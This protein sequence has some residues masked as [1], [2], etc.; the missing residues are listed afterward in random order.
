[1]SLFSTFKTALYKNYGE[2][3]GTMLVHTGA[4]GWILS[5]LAQISAIVFNDK[6]SKEQKSFLIP[7]EVADAM[8]NILSFYVVT[9]SFKNLAS[10]LVKTGK[11]T[12]KGIKNSL[13]ENGIESSQIGKF[14]FNIGDLPK[15]KVPK[16]YK[17]FKNGVDVI[18]STIGSV[19]SCNL[20]TPVLRN[21]YAS[22]QQK[23]T[24]ERWQNLSTQT[25][26]APQQNNTVK[27]QVK[28][29][30]RVSMV[31]FQRLSSGSSLKI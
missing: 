10:K 11:L 26:V 28:F 3:P 30:Q 18:A 12:T 13:L 15:D 9:S 5:S 24:L 20:I 4:L 19:I 22:K 23:N 17:S 27:P 25:V 6:I 31:D 1:M 14:D 29:P 8:I 21:V 2:N 16:G 7:Q